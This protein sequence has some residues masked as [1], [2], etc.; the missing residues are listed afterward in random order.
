M[1]LH[2]AFR[3]IE[4]TEALKARIEKR[5]EK[6]GKFVTYPME[7]HVRT[8]VEKNLHCAEITCHAEYRDFVAIAKTKDLYE[9]I[10]EAAH[11]I[12]GQLK[13]ERE[14]KK[15]HQ[16]AHGSVRLSVLKLAADVEAELPHLEKK[17]SRV[18]K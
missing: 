4:A 1:T 2:L 10:D 5:V 6:L 16:A 8:S 11:K 15:G 14:K 18:G 17:A 3:N 12:E 7:V 13:K 9:S